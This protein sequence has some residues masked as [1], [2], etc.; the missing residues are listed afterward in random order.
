[1]SLSGRIREELKSLQ[2]AVSQTEAF[3]E[4]LAARPNEQ[5]QEAL[6]TAISLNLHAFYT[7]AERIFAEIAKAVDESVP[8]G[9][10]W[11]KQLLLQMAATLPDIRSA[12]ISE[13]LLEQLDELRRFRH[14]VRSNYAHTL[15]R[16]RV[17]EQVEQLQA[18]W[19][20]LQAE[21]ELWLS[22]QLRD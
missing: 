22:I 13:E 9:N 19:E 15:D 20:A 1:M 12:V 2:R 10:E 18:C 5:L 21:L 4:Q 11:H 7:G 17:L 6:I 8:T 16:Q 14:V 3:V